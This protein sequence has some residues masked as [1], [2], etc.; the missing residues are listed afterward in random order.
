VTAFDFR[1]PCGLRPQPQHCIRL[2]PD[3]R[4]IDLISM[5]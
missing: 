2:R 5:R 4:G 1:H 3:H